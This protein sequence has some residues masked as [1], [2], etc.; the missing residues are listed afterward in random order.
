MLAGVCNA[1]VYMLESIMIACTDHCM[2]AFLKRKVAWG[3]LGLYL[4][5]VEHFKRNNKMNTVYILAKN[6]IYIT[7]RDVKV[8]GL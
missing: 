4:C 8:K 7:G 1:V 2:G 3:I 6:M 5:Q